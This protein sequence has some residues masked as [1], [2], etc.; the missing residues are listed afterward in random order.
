MSGL[1]FEFSDRDG[2]REV[3]VGFYDSFMKDFVAYDNYAMVE[4]GL[5]SLYETNMIKN[6]VQFIMV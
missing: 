6:D 1:I 5:E 2:V 4:Y 3:T